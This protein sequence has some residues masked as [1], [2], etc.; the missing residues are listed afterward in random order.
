MSPFPTE[1]RCHPHVPA[2]DHHPT[3]RN[4]PD[5][6]PKYA[7]SEKC[8]VEQSQA[9]RIVEAEDHQHRQR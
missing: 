5:M 1:N 3:R 2:I 9:K 7:S 8:C 6:A 4:D